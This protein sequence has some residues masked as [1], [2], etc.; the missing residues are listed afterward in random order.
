MMALL[1]TSFTMMGGDSSRAS[2][3]SHRLVG[4]T[5][6]SKAVVRVP[7]GKQTLLRRKR[8]QSIALPS[9]STIFSRWNIVKLHC[10][11]IEIRKD[12][13]NDCDSMNLVDANIVEKIY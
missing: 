6:D 8:P 4:K 2:L 11:D 5:S 3:M 13:T 9:V 7:E 12:T 10:S 1:F